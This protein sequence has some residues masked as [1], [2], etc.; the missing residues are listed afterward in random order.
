ML[1]LSL[2]AFLR[3]RRLSIVSNEVKIIPLSVAAL[4]VLFLSCFSS[5]SAPDVWVVDKF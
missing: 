2:C 5:L 3:D 4:S 1:E